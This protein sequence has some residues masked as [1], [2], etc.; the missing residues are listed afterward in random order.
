MRSII[1]GKP[2]FSYNIKPI[3]IGNGRKIL[4]YPLNMIFSAEILIKLC[5]SKQN[6]YDNKTPGHY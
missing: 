1:T 6:F 4:D 5:G 3:N 2:L